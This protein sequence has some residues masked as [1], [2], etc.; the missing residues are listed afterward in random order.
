MLFFWRSWYQ[1]LFWLHHGKKFI[2]CYH[3]SRIIRI[4]C[5]FDS[6]TE[7]TVIIFFFRNEYN[8]R[9]IYGDNCTSYYTMLD[10]YSE[11]NCR[12]MNMSLLQLLFTLFQTVLSIVYTVTVWY[13]IL[14][15]KFIIYFLGNEMIFKAVLLQIELNNFYNIR[16]KFWS[17]LLCKLTFKFC[18]QLL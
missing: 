17:N 10:I 14:R 6:C 13:T 1:W 2:I 7:N 5:S 15:T 11:K 12:W 8:C 9:S 3:I 4:L 16:S 18:M